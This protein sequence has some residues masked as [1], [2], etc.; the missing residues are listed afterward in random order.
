MTEEASKKYLVVGGSGFIGR[1]VCQKLTEQGAEVYILSRSKENALKKLNPFWRNALSQCHWVNQLDPSMCFDGVINLSGKS[2]ADGLWTK[3]LK[4][5]IYQSRIGISQMLNHYFENCDFKPKI[6]INASGISIYGKYKK[7]GE[8]EI[9]SDRLENHFSQ[10]LCVD[11]EQ[12]ALKAEKYGIRV[13]LLRL[14]VVIGDGGYL[15]RLKWPLKCG[16]NIQLG[17]D[18]HTFQWIHMDDVVGSI[19]LMLKIESMKGPVNMVA[20]EV[21]NLKDLSLIYRYHFK[22]KI[23][24][25]LSDHVVRFLFGAMGRELLLT[26]YVVQPNK[27]CENK[28][29]FKCLEFKRNFS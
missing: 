19:M 18:H 28:Y 24:F 23:N 14:G 15:K 21:I 2:L 1:H 16:L 10:N 6:L 27:L 26:N 20:P 25:R 7:N 5:E 29:N 3:S 9:I 13:C 8:E 22:T 12:E 4:N 11:W 17:E